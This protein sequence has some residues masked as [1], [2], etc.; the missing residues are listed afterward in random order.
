MQEKLLTQETWSQEE[1]AKVENEI[2]KHLADTDVETQAL[3]P[4]LQTKNKNTTLGGLFIVWFQASIK[5]ASW[6]CGALATTLFGLSPGTAIMSLICGN[7]VGGII[8]YIAAA[9]GRNGA[10]QVMMMIPAFGRQGSRVPRFLLFIT[11]LGWTIANTVFAT[12]L[13]VGILKLLAPDIST[14]L[15]NTILVAFLLAQTIL[16]IWVANKKFDFVVKILK[17]FTYAMIVVLIV[18]TIVALRVMDWTPRP[19]Q[20][21]GGISLP[22]MF[23]S[24]MS[25]L[26]VGYLGTW[27][28]FASDFTRYVNMEN[29]AMQRRTGFVSAL[30]G[31]VCCTWLLGLGALMG[32]MYNEIDPAVAIA[33]TMP[34]LIIPSLF[35]VLVGSWSSLIVNFISCGIDLKS[36]GVKVSR[37]NATAIT[38]VV[39][40]ILGLISFFLADIATL[41]FRFLLFLVIWHMPWIVI[42]A[43]D[44]Y[45]VAKCDYDLKGMYG[46][47]NKYEGYDKPAI[48]S[49]IVGFFASY[50]FCF[51]GNLMIGPIPLYSPLMVKYFH[52]GDFSF[53]VGA[54]V[55]S[56]LYYFL[57]VRPRLAK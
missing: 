47:N 29:K 32:H 4:V 53:I 51:P 9:M 39:V 24:I 48:I 37:A 7:L 50:A 52:Y 27:S 16:S 46:L 25:A 22:I 19:E 57:S 20:L 23:I 28:P 31:F 34:I 1:R 44:Y 45:V 30:S 40:V 49:M 26:G 35:I 2:V 15:H 33:Q 6:A 13:A 36:L 21:T 54:V 10:P 17:P 8:V 12:L 11:V 42:Q 41:Y 56:I 3:A 14:G 55:T 5:P 43:F 18:M 38:G